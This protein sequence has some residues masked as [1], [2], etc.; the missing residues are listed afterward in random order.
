MAR[1]VRFEQAGVMYRVI[2]RGNYR[3]WIFENEGAKFSFE[4]SSLEVYILL[5]KLRT[6]H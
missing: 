6:E 5:P 4:E 3:S 2:N 1:K